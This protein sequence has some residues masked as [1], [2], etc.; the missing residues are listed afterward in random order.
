MAVQT[1]QPDVFRVGPVATNLVEVTDE[2][3]GKEQDYEV[4]C[5]ALGCER[6]ACTHLTFDEATSEVREHAEE[7]H[8]I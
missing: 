2:E 1:L 7:V 4:Q 5:E 6:Y 8:A 3:G